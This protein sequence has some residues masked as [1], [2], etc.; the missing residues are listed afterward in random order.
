[1]STVAPNG[2]VR[3]FSDVPLDPSHIDT[4]WFDSRQSQLS[5][6]L[7]L[8]PVQ[9]M[10][11]STRIRNGVVSFN[12]GEDAIR[13]CNYMMFQN[14]NFSDKWFFAYILKTEYVNNGLTYVYY[15]IDAMQ[16]YGFDITLMDCYVERETTATDEIGE[17]TLGENL[18][19]PELKFSNRLGGEGFNNNVTAT[20][21][22]SAKMEQ[23]GNWTTAPITVI[24]NLM[25]MTTPTVRADYIVNGNIVPA[26][27]VALESVVQDLVENNYSE[28]I[29]G[30]VI[31][32]TEFS[33]TT[34]TSNIHIEQ[35]EW[36]Q[37]R[38]SLDGYVPK[39]NKMFNSPYCV[40]RLQTSDGQAVF[41]QPEYMT[42]DK[43][44]F[45]RVATCSM[46]PEVA[47]IPMGYKGQDYAYSEALSISNFPQ[48]SIAIDGYKA[49]V[50]SGGLERAQLELS[51]ITRSAQLKQTQNVVNS[52]IDTVGNTASIISAGGEAY[53]TGGLKG[54]D[55]VIS[56]SVKA[57]K[58]LSN[59]IFTEL[60]LENSITFAN[61][62]FDLQNAIA[63]TFPPSTKG[64]SVGNALI[65]DLKVGYT[66]DRFTINYD[67]AKAIDDYFTMYGYRVNTL[68]KPTLHNRNRFTY[69]KTSGCKVN[70]GAPSDMITRIENILNAGCRFWADHEHMCDY[71][72]APN[73]PLGNN[74]N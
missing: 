2:Q 22:T 57:T 66:V 52:T 4:L 6:F 51:Q 63:K 3:L 35:Y 62:N 34:Q 30:G 25:T 64:H 53:L 21:F 36:S 59:A 72:Y 20:I 26:S 71:D 12:V 45:R 48:F 40:I 10:N 67:N 60:E 37:M 32:P 28:S 23:Q 61:E 19:G 9:V 13:H 70:G 68:K 18:G 41:L 46:T 44:R 8:T 11:N 50:A 5:Y 15:D 7:S 49:W 58:D 14:Q 33:I 47:I 24:N 29:I 54:T 38:G 42:G 16:T 74:A 39:N 69:V 1:M 65:S 43:I 27:W 73:V 56:S 17:H 31:M 55:E